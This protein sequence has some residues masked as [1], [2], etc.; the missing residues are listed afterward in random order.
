MARARG[1][2]L[3]VAR[4]GAGDVLIEAPPGWV[5]RLCGVL[6]DNACRYAGP[7]AGSVSWWPLT[8]TRSAWRSKTVGRVSP[9]T[10]GRYS[11]TV[12]SGAT[13]GAKVPGSGWPSPT[14]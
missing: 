2:A 13:T 14:P 1:I 11:S 9:L 10:R 7:A 3:S 6:V 8:G 12:S 5:D 4:E